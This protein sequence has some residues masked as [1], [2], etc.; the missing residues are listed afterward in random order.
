MGR[1]SIGKFP[2]AASGSSAHQVSE[3]ARFIVVARANARAQD[4]SDV[5]EALEKDGFTT[6]QAQA[7]ELNRR[8][9]ETARGGLWHPNSVARLRKRLESA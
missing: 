3:R 5:L 6:L 9:F 7:D 8:G 4:L 2:L 1:L